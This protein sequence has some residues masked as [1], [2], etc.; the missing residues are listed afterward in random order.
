MIFLNQVSFVYAVEYTTA[1]TVALIFG[2]TPVFVGL[3][4]I[5]LRLGRLGR[6]FWAGALVTLAGVALVAA[7][8][9]TGF[10][11][12]L[13]GNLLAVACARHLG[14][15]LARGRAAD[16]PLLAVP[17]LGARARARLGAARGRR[18]AP[19]RRA[20]PSRSAA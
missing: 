3:I 4:S 17:D 9:G 18:R 1:S 14:D 11:G 7:G 12:D 5:A 13:K 19:D 20:S 2:A 15:V 8:S 6:R 10:S 16:A